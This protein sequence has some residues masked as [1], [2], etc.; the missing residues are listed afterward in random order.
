MF[1]DACAIV[2]MFME[3]DS[4]PGY[5]A[6]LLAADNPFTSPL[7]AWEAIIVLAHPSRLNVSFEAARLDVM[8]WLQRSA[9]VLRDAGPPEAVLAHAVAVAQTHGVGKRALSNFDC[10]H[11]AQARA[12]GTPLLTLDRL[13]QQTDVETRP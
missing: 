8:E 4:K 6:A 2:A 7:A 9:I 5:E 1:V 3:E 13:L 11:Y 12:A 10:F